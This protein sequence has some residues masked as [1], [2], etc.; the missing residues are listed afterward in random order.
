MGM[1]GPPSNSPPVVEVARLVFRNVKACTSLAGTGQVHQLP[2]EAVQRPWVY[3][4][5]TGDRLFFDREE[6]AEW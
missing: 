2:G 5:R 4:C 3:F 1:D 6:Q